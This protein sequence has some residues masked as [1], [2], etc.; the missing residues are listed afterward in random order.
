MILEW[1]END[2][3][4]IFDDYKPSEG[5]RERSMS[6]AQQWDDDGNI[7]GSSDDNHANF[8]EWQL[9]A[10]LKAQ[11]MPEPVESGVSDE[12]LR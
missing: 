10:I 9:Q 11:G 3:R 6:D 4:N 2:P 1:I 12:D 7:L 8:D 5:Q